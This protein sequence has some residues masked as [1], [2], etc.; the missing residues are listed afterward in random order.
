[1]A[2]RTQSTAKATP[3]PVPSSQAALDARVDPTA[4]I[5]SNVDELD[6]RE[7]RD[8]K[9]DLDFSKIKFIHSSLADH[10]IV[11]A[12]EMLKNM[13][14]QLGAQSSRSEFK[15]VKDMFNKTFRIVDRN[16]RNGKPLNENDDLK[17]FI[18]M[19][20]KR[21]EQGETTRVD[22]LIK[23]ENIFEQGSHKNR[24]KFFLSS[25]DVGA[26]IEI[27]K[28]NWEFAVQTYKESKEIAE[29]NFKKS[30]YDA[31]VEEYNSIDGNRS[32]SITAIIMKHESSF[33]YA[34]KITEAIDAY[35]KSLQKINDDLATAFSK[36]STDL[37]KNWSTMAQAQATLMLENKTDSLTLWKSIK[38]A[39][40]TL[41]N[42]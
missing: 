29:D 21:L 19:L 7:I 5:D 22:G 36:L 41:F 38:T 10:M 39:Y 12:D 6:E 4:V 37:I 15:G 23:A 26:K 28:V 17:N 16:N 2:K 9:P 24:N 35:G 34:A 11:L 25:I 20:T 8:A 3:T 27:A 32:N 13:S 42:K 1:M 33:G 18:P 14:S 40:N 30:I 31:Y